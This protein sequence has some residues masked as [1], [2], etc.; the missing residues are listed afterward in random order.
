MALLRET[1]EKAIKSKFGKFKN[2]AEALGID[3]STFTKNLDKLSDN[4]VRRLIEVGV[5]LPADSIP[6]IDNA[7]LR[8]LYKKVVSVPLYSS[9]SAGPAELIV[10]EPIDVIYLP[11]NGNNRFAVK[12]KGESMYPTIRHGDIVVADPD[13]ERIM[14]GDICLVANEGYEY[15]LKRVYFM[16]D[17]KVKC[18]PDNS[19]HPEIFYD[20][21][22]IR[23]I[24]IVFHLRDREQLRR[25]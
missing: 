2:C 5:E 21:D 10:S 22:T 14:D 19:E 16:T 4:F 7:E 15:T 11:I 17:G 9:A 8:T 12:V 24:P 3:D 18:K 25:K 6:H 23:I 1:V 13:A 20:K